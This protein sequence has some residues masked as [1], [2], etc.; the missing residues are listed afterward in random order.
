MTVQEI[1]EKYGGTFSAIVGSAIA[2]VLMI[3]E[4]EIE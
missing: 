4:K 3:I 1:F 2:D